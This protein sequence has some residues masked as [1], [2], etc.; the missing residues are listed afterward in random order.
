MF[1]PNWNCPRGHCRGRFTEFP[2][3]SKGAGSC[4]PFAALWEISHGSTGP[5]LLGKCFMPRDVSVWHRGAGA[6][7]WGPPLYRSPHKAV[8][9][10]ITAACVAPGGGR[11]PSL[12]APTL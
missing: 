6:R 9:Y 12:G 7:V 2:P 8:P 10:P 11:G 1:C 5:K 3:P 4:N